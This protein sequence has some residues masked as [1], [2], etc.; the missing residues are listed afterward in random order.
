[1]KQTIKTIIFLGL[2]LVGAGQA[3]GENLGYIA[4]TQGNDD[5]GSLAFYQD[6]TCTSEITI[7]DGKS[8]ALTGQLG[9]DGKVYI[10]VTPDATHQARGVTITVEKKVDSV[11]PIPPTGVPWWD[12]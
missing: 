2:M 9:T 7:T 12:G 1:M 8:G 10:K 4:Y 5:G 3:W 6:A 11:D